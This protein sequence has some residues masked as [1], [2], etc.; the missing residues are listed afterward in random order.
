LNY[1]RVDGSVM[2]SD[3]RKKCN[4]EVL[5]L[6]TAVRLTYREKEAACRP[7]SSR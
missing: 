7:T 4:S 3:R 5:R 6:R 2:L 1:A